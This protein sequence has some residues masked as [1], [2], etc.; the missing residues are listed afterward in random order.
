MERQ[1]QLTRRKTEQTPARHV[2]ER[3]TRRPAA[4]RLPA[5]ALTREVLLSDAVCELS[6]D[7][8]EAL[9][10]LLGNS[11]LAELLGGLDDGPETF[12]FPDPGSCEGEETCNRI[13]TSAP[14]LYRAEGLDRRTGPIPRASGPG[15]VRERSAPGMDSELFGIL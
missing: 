11:A 6:P 9:A 5:E 13:C 2:P 3:E 8:L 1:E 7:H 15:R 10:E 12:A 4:E 14:G